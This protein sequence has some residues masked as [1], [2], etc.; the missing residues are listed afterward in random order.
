MADTEQT[1]KEYFK[2]RQRKWR[3]KGKCNDCGNWALP[4]KARCQVCQGKALITVNRWQARQKAKKQD[5]AGS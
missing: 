1:A 3:A 5:A 2:A 4:G